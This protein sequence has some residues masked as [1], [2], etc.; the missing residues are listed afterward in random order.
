MASCGLRSF[1]ELHKLC[2]LCASHV[3]YLRSFYQFMVA[4]NALIL[5]AMGL[6]LLVPPERLRVWW[7]TRRAT[8]WALFA[9]DGP[10][11]PW[12]A[13]SAAVG[14]GL[15]VWGLF[16]WKTEFGFETQAMKIA[17]VEFGS[18]RYSLTR[19]SF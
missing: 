14:Y 19:H 1:P 17:L 3:D 11:W 4:V 10:Q 8:P 16:A 2:V 5:F 12:L 7:R 9:E 6:A 15:L 18:W 13:C